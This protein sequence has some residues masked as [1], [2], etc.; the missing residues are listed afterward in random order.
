MDQA[1]TLSL[2]RGEIQ[3]IELTAVHGGV[4]IDHPGDSIG[5]SLIVQLSR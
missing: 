4:K 3:L 2:G 1:N 5:S